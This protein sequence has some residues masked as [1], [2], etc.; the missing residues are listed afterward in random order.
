MK[1][2]LMI[3]LTVCMVVSCMIVPSF[4]FSPDDYT[5]IG[6][7]NLPADGMDYIISY[8]SDYDEFFLISWIPADGFTIYYDSSD[9]FIKLHEMS[10]FYMDWY[11]KNGWAEGGTLQSKDVHHLV[12]SSIQYPVYSTVNILD[13]DG[14]LFFPPA[15]PLAEV[16]EELTMEQS[17]AVQNQTV[18][19]MKILVPC[20]VGCLA[21]LM[22]LP[23][24][25]KG[26]LRFLH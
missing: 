6:D 22:A 26:F 17:M 18:G 25:R 11:G 4:A 19:V 15:V 2:F 5:I 8:N 10:S 13:S 9:S 16:V 12:V 20:G 21:L 7:L 14:E 23:T 24:L 3:F 1:K